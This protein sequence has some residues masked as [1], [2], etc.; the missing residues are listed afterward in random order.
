VA[1]DEA[2]QERQLSVEE[3]TAARH[4]GNGEL[5]R[6]CP[7]HH[8]RQS[9]GVVQLTMRDERPLVRIVRK[10]GYAKARHRRSDKHDLFRRTL[11]PQPRN[12]AGCDER[13]E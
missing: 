11:V 7:I 2:L 12:G 13:T 1:S 3:M 8:S 4:N 9:D 5:L 10:C 6:P